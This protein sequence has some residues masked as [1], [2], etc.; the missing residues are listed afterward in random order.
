M[1]RRKKIKKLE[2]QKQK[3]MLLRNYVIYC[4]SMLEN[5]ELKEQNRIKQQEPIK[6]LILTKPFYGRELRVE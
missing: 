1:E 4:K 2:T 3:Y 6:T 5:M